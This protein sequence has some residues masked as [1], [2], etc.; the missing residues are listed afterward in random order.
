MTEA[1][2]ETYW[3]W[4]N[5]RWLHWVDVDENTWVSCLDLLDLINTGDGNFIQS[6]R[7]GM[8]RSM[9]FPQ[10]LR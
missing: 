6:K 1:N 3:T 8:R 10:F 2:G 7:L 4:D 5:I 9:G